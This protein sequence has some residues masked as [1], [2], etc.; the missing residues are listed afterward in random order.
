MK[1]II[2]GALFILFSFG[3]LF[4]HEPKKIELDYDPA[5]AMLSANIEHD[6]IDPGQH[7][8]LQ[9]DIFVNGKRR[10]SYF[11]ERQTNP[12]GLYAKFRVDADRADKIGLTAHCS[13]IGE[14]KA[15]LEVRRGYYYSDTGSD[16]YPY[17]NRYPNYIIIP[18]PIHKGNRTDP[19]LRH[20]IKEHK[21]ADE[22][23]KALQSKDRRELER[24]HQK[25]HEEHALEHSE[26]HPGVP[27]N[28]TDPRHLKHH[29]EEHQLL[30]EVQR[31][32]H[33]PNSAPH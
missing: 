3:F 23:N 6:V 11:F 29:S 12:D 22:A 26:L 30:N 5:N 2:I 28:S 25:L 15:M 31:A 21:L 17:N 13:S 14:S 7:Y 1:S 8:I 4:A 10:Q 27:A 20:H 19:A 9:V 24:A 16:L 33:G 18:Q 32:L